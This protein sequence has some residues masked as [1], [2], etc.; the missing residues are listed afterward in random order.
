MSCPQCQGIEQVFNSKTAAR[1]LKKYRQKGAHKATKQLIEALREAGVIDKSLLDIG[2]GV[3]AIQHELVAAGVTDV[4]N[5]DA[6]PDYSNSARQEAQRQGYSS[7]ATYYQGDFV[8]LASMIEP[9]DIVTLDSVI[10]CYHDM[11]ALVRLSVE[12]A[13]EYYGLIY[14]IDRWWLKALRPIFNGTFW[15]RRNPYRIFLHATKSVDE[16][17]RSY[18]FSQGYYQQYWGVAQIVLYERQSL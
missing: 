14:P 15:L 12:R 9:A 6:S 8:D 10:C 2:G 1:Q 5:V 16:L 13:K 17:V 11:N 7:L 18:G 3:G 4:V